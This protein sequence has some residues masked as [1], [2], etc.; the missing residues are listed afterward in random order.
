[1]AT[2]CALDVAKALPG[3]GFQVAPAL[4]PLPPGQPA[5]ARCVS[6]T[7]TTFGAPRTGN[8]AFARD[9]NRHVPDAWSVINRQDP[10]ALGGRWLG[11]PGGAAAAPCRQRCA[12]CPQVPQHPL[13]LPPTPFAGLKSPL[14]CLLPTT[15]AM[16]AK[17]VTLF[18]RPGKVVLLSARGDLLVRPAAIEVSAHTQ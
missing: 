15:V 17:F 14:L 8:H 16:M 4:L 12:E 10:G 5:G 3:W 1:M 13:P 6:L 2:L 18:K 11:R 9:F 7:C